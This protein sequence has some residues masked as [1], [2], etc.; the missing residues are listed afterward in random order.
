MCAAV[1]T[2]SKCFAPLYF[3]EHDKKTVVNLGNPGSKLH[4]TQSKKLEKLSAMPKYPPATLSSESAAK[5]GR[6]CINHSLSSRG[7]ERENKKLLVWPLCIKVIGL[8]RG[9]Q[10]NHLFD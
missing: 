5:V 8:V 3:T 9:H 7:M 6:T 1:C 4:D 2:M 10:T